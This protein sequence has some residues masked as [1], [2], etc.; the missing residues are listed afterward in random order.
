LEGSAPNPR[1]QRLGHEHLS[2]RELSSRTSAS[3]P[4]VAGRPLT[5]QPFGGL[6]ARG[7]HLAE[8]R[9]ILAR[10]VLVAAV[11]LSAACSTS[12]VGGGCSLSCNPQCEGDTG[13]VATGT[14]AAACFKPCRVTSDCGAGT[15]CVGLDNVNCFTSNPE[16][17]KQPRFCLPK[18]ATFCP[19]ALPGT[20]FDGQHCDFTDP[21]N[22]AQGFGSP[23]GCGF[24]YVRCPNGCTS[25]TDG[26]SP[27]G[28][29]R[30][31]P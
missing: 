3:R 5:R 22:L 10:V 9:Q 19:G 28:T 1:L 13:C 18:E 23:F 30:C 17:D 26:G 27:P 7:V 6:P 31:A 21:S 16:G 12:T 15:H 2:P 8:V 24:E 29:P 4:A 14:V 11:V 20:V 25:G